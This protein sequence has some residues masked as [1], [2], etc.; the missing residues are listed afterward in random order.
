MSRGDRRQAPREHRIEH[1]FGQA[2]VGPG[3]RAVAVEN[4]GFSLGESCLKM[5]CP[6]LTLC[7]AGA[8]RVFWAVIGNIRPNSPRWLRPGRQRAVREG[9]CQSLRPGKSSRLDFAASERRFSARTS[10]N[11]AT[12]PR[13]TMTAMAPAY[14]SDTPTK[15][16]AALRRFPQ[17]PAS[18]RLIREMKLSFMI[19]AKMWRTCGK[20]C[21]YS[22]VTA[23][24]ENRT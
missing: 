12:Q 3:P 13:A 20:F 16:K 14:M 9:S 6:C 2:G 10:N 19:W 1:V 22:D 5:R 21:T 7:K 11:S 15:S 4:V 17:N 23:A 24:P 18:P 8:D